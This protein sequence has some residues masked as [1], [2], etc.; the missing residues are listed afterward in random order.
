MENSPPSSQH[1]SL[2]MERAIQAL[3]ERQRE[4]LQLLQD[5]KA[6]KE[7]ASLLGISEGTVK[8]HLVSIFKQLKVKNRTMAANLG[9]LSQQHGEQ[10]ST[11]AALTTQGEGGGDAGSG[12]GSM[13]YASAMQPIS[14][15]VVRLRL[16]EA[17]VHRLGSAHFGE[18]NRALQ[19]VCSEGVRRFHGVMQSI[20]GGVLLLFG[21]PHMREDDPERAACCA[22]WLQEAMGSH[23]VGLLVREEIPLRL[24]ILSGSVV[25]AADGGKITLHGDIITHPCLLTPDSCTNDTH[26]HISEATRQALRTFRAR[27]GPP[28]VFFPVGDALLRAM[29]PLGVESMDSGPFVGREA[30]LQR[31]QVL[32]SR[33][34]VGQSQTVIVVG[35]AGFG[36]TRLI[37]E[38]QTV[39]VREGG[40]LWQESHCRTL[41]GQTPWYPFA[42]L[43]AQLSGVSPDKSLAVQGAQM[44]AWLLQHYPQ[45]EA[46]GR[47]LIDLL[48]GTEESTPIVEGLAAGVAA[49][50]REVLTAL[51]R[52]TVLFLDN[53]QW[54]DSDTLD[55]FPHLAQELHGT[56]VWLIGS[57]R[58]LWLRSHTVNRVELEQGE[59]VPVDAILS[60]LSLSRLPQKQTIQLVR[61]CHPH[62]EREEGLMRR[63]AQWSSGVPLFAT[64]LSRQA[65]ATPTANHQELLTLF[66]R[67]LHALILERLDA[68]KVDWR[69]V[70]AIAAHGRIA[71]R[72]LLALGIYPNSV[73]EAAVDHL[74][75]VGLLGEAE[76]E[77]DR[78]LFFN[79]EMV[80]AAV[81]LTLLQG[82]RRPVA[83]VSTGR[84]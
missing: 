77:K 2:A 22:F 35:E 68:A 80:R 83:T 74:V 32:A 37:R 81:W 38:L 48:T 45:H 5:G 9:L 59:Y 58:R 56:H 11:E 16:S 67:S 79:N 46:S 18:T 47:R 70:R 52:P 7:I 49:L 26:P 25:T 60:S 61:A 63:M 27:Y 31:L 39:L 82:D 55:L 34:R 53:L 64:E 24:C 10:V 41:A 71:R 8:Q 1:L 66:P 72:R 40:W 43:L 20:P 12:G 75:K 36:K 57:T 29:G 78:E 84:I 14:I 42:V 62:P 73:A 17:M 15:V 3:T 50:L 19:Q 54:A 51:E 76:G 65:A 21:V 23:P 44:Q 33:A 69:M 4:I 6:N 30:E 13:Q 28:T